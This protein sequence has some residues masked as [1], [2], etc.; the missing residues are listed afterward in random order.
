MVMMEIYI[1]WDGDWTGH[2]LFGYLFDMEVE[3]PLSLTQ[4]Y[5]GYL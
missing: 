1:E 2:D 5:I 4:T 3:F